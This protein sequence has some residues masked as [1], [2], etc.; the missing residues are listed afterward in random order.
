MFGSGWKALPEVREWSEGP[1]GCPGVVRRFS[2][3][4]KSGLQAL[5]DV[6][7]ALPNI[8]ELSGDRS[9]CPGVVGKSSHMSVSG[10]EAYPD[11]R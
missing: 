5:P 3:M 10:W 2:Q 6:R 7:V 4:S 9:G 8:W 1:R 11:V